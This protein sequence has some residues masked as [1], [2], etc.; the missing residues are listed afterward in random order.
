MTLEVQL[1][2]TFHLTH[3][4]QALDAM[5]SSPRLQAL[6]AYL[7]LHH[8]T[9]QPRQ[10]I[11][12]HFWPV[13]EEGQA[14]TNLRKL[15][16][17]LRRALPD[18]DA[19]LTFDNQ[20][21]GWQCDDAVHCDVH[22]V[23]ALLG[24]L[25]NNPLD[26]DA[27]TALFARYRGELLP[28]C[29]DDWIVPLRERLHQDVMAALDQLV[30]L[31]E[32]QRAYSEGIRYAQRLLSFDPLEEKSYQRLM[33]LRAADGD[34]AGAL[35]VYQECTEILE[36][37]LGVEPSTATAAL[38]Q[39]LLNGEETAPATGAAQPP[40]VD[41]LPL[42]GREA[43]WQQLRQTWQRAVRGQPGFVTIVGAAGIGKTR[44]AEELLHWV[45][46]QG[47]AVVRARAYQS[48]G[49]LAY[50]PIA[51]LL[52]TPPIQQRLAALNATRL[53]Q[54]ARLLPELLE[55]HPDLAAPQ[56]M[57]EGWQRQQFFD[58]LAHA[59]LADR[60]PLLMLLDDLQW[61]DVETVAWLHF[62][63]RA[64]EQ[65]PLLIVGT[66][67]TG[68]LDTKHPLPTFLSSLHR[69]N[70]LTELQLAPLTK[71][72]VAA[73]VNGF[74][75]DAHTQALAEPQL[76]QLY[77]D[78]EGN[79]L[80]VVEMMRAQALQ[81]DDATRDH[82]GNGLPAKIEAMIQTRLAHL[83]PEAH[84][85]VNL[86]SVIGRSFDY[87]LLQASGSWEEEQ[88][89]DLLD[90]LLEREIIREQSGDTY[91]FAHDSL[92]EVA[93]AGIS[94]TRRR[95]LHRRVAQALEAD[96]KSAPT[97]LLTAT[98]AHH[99][100][101][102][103]NQEQAIHYLL[104]AGDQA[105][106]LYANAEAE[107]FYQQAVPLLRTQGADEQAARTLMKLG[108]VYT[109]R[110]DFAKAQQVYEEAFALWQPAAT[111][112]LP[113]HNNLLPATLRVA[114]GQPSRPDPALA[115]DSDSA[116][117]LEQLFEGLVE[118]DQDQNVVPALALRWAVLDDGARYRFTL[119]PD[120][121]WSDGSP[122]TAE[123]VELSWKRNLNPTLD[124]PAA[125]LL[126]DIRNARAY[127]SGALADPAQVGVRAL[128]PVTLEV[129][130]EGPRAYFPYLLAHPITYPVPDGLAE[131]AGNACTEPATLITNGPYVLTEW[132]PGIQL[133]LERN[134]FYTGSFPGNI[135][136]VEGLIFSQWSKSLA[137]YAAPQVAHD[138]GPQTTQGVELIDI[139]ATTPQQMVACR[140]NYPNELVSM[141]LYNTNYLVFRV[142][143]P[144][145]DDVRVRKALIHAINRL[146]LGAELAPQ[147][148]T[149][150][151]GGIV[152]PGM[153]GH[154]P[155]IGLTYSPLLAKEL[156]AEA[157][158]AV[159][160][161][162]GR[163][164][165]A[166][167]FLHTHGLGDEKQIQF[168]QQSWQ[169][170]LGITIEVKT[171]TW[172]AFQQQL[173]TE[174]PHLMLSSWLADY[175]DPDNFLRGLFHS[176]EGQNEPRWHNAQFD[177]GV[178]AA[179]RETNPERRLALYRELDQLLIEQEAVVMPLSYG[180]GTVLMKPWL[181]H[182]RYGRVY[183]RYLK[184][185]V[186]ER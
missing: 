112:Q 178:T 16:L 176:S 144:P 123:Q 172:D 157:G 83:S 169:Q 72:E 137:A 138:S 51:D 117:L 7:L 146:A 39:R 64:A 104:T 85:V 58:A 119:R 22:A 181:R 105:R 142:D 29:Y 18:A 100:V 82:T 177:A 170:Q 23:Q 69:D 62:L 154:S 33:R 148:Q 102:A 122:V 126:F 165:P 139:S 12:Y 136:R 96:H 156:L 141:P 118:I 185:L 150:A 75:V 173:A 103:G 56:P 48:Q 43:E 114:I 5:N 19:Y 121:K 145:F 116:F 42:V 131:V 180:K 133:R 166:V 92:R 49:A 113:D 95:L 67:R 115:Y 93:Y 60:K 77:A 36:R 109:A 182:H 175:P 125:H 76:A 45:N 73:L 44:L 25:H 28:S 6:L 110:F 143:C 47:V 65:T 155:E 30:T 151:L 129:W 89:V 106:Q 46:S 149:P 68:E 79:P 147:G 37:E 55:R 81:P 74:N 10:Q 50:A 135:E 8:D 98:L 17:Q 90:E 124:A 174:P 108:L 97:G 91:D 87:G 158:Y 71:A 86:A 54:I 41:R 160:T 161:Q 152:P 70:L 13:S 153:P 140:R 53:S 111:P 183:S 171:V 11:A 163:P 130:L 34:R 52:Q 27:L 186:V 3:N 101:E 59:V 167:S 134:P 35:K 9:P 14:R 15:F 31:L 21:I 24:R 88:L 164:F 32:N 20:T 80:F 57:T 26:Q 2:G 162:K 120:A 4:G 63:I 168:L 128:D 61:A 159:G 66:L 99:Y 78:T 179:A 132:Q 94:R 127:H 38:Y 107:H 40:A 1:F 84:T 184:K